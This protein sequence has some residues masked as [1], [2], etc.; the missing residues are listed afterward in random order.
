MFCVFLLSFRSV[1]VRKKLSCFVFG[2]PSCVEAA[3]KI[4]AY[5]SQ[6]AMAY[7]ILSIVSV[8]FGVRVGYHWLPLFQPVGELG[9]ETSEFRALK[10]L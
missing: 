4:S 6:K 7:V 9:R 8:L 10:W 3:R 2:Y 1:L 5:W